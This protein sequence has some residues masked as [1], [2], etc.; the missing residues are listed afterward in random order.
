MLAESERT[1][2]WMVVKKLC[3]NPGHELVG[4]QAVIGEELSGEMA[5][6]CQ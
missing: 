4:L 6:I 2:G 1:P 5:L 3:P